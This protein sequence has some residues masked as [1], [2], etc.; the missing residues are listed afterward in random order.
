LDRGETVAMIKGILF[1]FDG[2]IGKTMEDNY[3]AWKQAL[4]PHGIRLTKEEY[5]LLEGIST[6]DLAARLLTQYG[7]DAAKAPE[8]VKAKEDYYLRHNSFS[9]YPGATEILRVLKTD[10][11]R[12]AIVT[13]ANHSR[14]SATLSSDVMGLFDA[15]VT[16]DNVSRGKPHPDPYLAGAKMLSLVPAE[17]LVVENA[18]IGIAAAK[19]AGMYCVA[20][21]STLD[22][23]EL[24]RADSII[25]DISGLLNEIKTAQVKT[26]I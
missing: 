18:P 24:S 10:G 11:F 4:S 14:L 22:P 3:A 7:K 5:F 1:D 15:V 21:A 17:C 16:G 23:K 8:V 19:N 6:H 13:A 2:V 20:I 26:G 9:V 25:G 12:L